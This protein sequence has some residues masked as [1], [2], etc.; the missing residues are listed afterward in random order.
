MRT[1]TCPVCHVTMEVVSLQPPEGATVTLDTCLTCGALW[2]DRGELERGS[3]R[4]V[5][6]THTNDEVDYLCPRCDVHLWAQT[7]GEHNHWASACIRC[8]GVFV[9]GE[10]VDFALS[11]HPTAARLINAPRA[12][13]PNTTRARPRPKLRKKPVD[14]LEHINVE[15]C[16][17]CS[18]PASDTRLVLSLRVTG[19]V[20]FSCRKKLDL[21]HSDEAARRVRPGAW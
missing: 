14:Y 10:S 11:L 9:D 5:S 20:C 21:L 3:K 12:G 19:W 6:R 13:T 16:A 2:F 18:E 1:A 4:K 17:W 7:L 8:D 15:T